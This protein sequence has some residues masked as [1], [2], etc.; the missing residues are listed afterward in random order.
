MSKN[1]N[2]VQQKLFSIVLVWIAFVVL[3]LT[4]KSGNDMF[5][6]LGLG[7]MAVANGVLYLKN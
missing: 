1:D 3:Y 6:W 4:I 5:M 7:F 2:V